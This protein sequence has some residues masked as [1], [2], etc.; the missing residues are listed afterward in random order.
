MEATA[1][2]TAVEVALMVAVK[3]ARLAARS[4]AR[5]AEGMAVQ[6]ACHRWIGCRRCGA[7]GPQ[8]TIMCRAT[9][10]KG[11]VKSKLGR[12]SDVLISSV[13]VP[14]LSVKRFQAVSVSIKFSPAVPRPP[15]LLYSGSHPGRACVSL[16]GACAA[17][18]LLLGHTVAD[19]GSGAWSESRQLRS[20][21]RRPLET[22]LLNPSTTRR[23]ACP[24]VSG[25]RRPWAGGDRLSR[26]CS[27]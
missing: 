23:Q 7:N 14:H 12:R 13:L 15:R 16:S 5:A 24:A 11:G 1:A 22:P 26:S 3:L 17:S 9:A 25:A 20:P 21:L 6:L 10:R 19:S 2:E 27:G 8:R 4:L 18:S